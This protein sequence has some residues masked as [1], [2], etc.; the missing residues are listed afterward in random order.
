GYLLSVRISVQRGAP[1][2][3]NNWVGSTQIAGG[4]GGNAGGVELE[5][6]QA[7]LSG[8]VIANNAINDK[9]GNGGGVAIDGG[10]PVTLTNN[11]IDGNSAATVA[12]PAPT[13]SPPPTAYGGG[14][15]VSGAPATM[16]GNT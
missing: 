10:G 11:T 15:Y 2:V 1:S 7:T 4:S 14:V 16:T 5:S 9:Y 8:N 12:V 3:Q 6:T 13:P